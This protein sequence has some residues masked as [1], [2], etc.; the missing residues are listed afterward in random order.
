MSDA[1]DFADQLAAEDRAKQS[2]Y[3]LTSTRGRWGVL[4]LGGVLLTVIRPAGLVP[5][6]WS[7]V[8][9]FA[10][11]FAAINYAMAR[12]AR[13]ETLPPWYTH[14]TLAAGAAGRSAAV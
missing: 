14:A 9:G 12:V 8:L 13:S 3:V 4:G 7:F 5:V 2:R 10:V 1:A 6:A 11:V